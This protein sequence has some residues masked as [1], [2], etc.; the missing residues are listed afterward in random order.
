LDGRD[1][2]NLCGDLQRTFGTAAFAEQEAARELSFVDSH[3]VADPQVNLNE[4]AAALPRTAE[5]LDMRTMFSCLRHHHPMAHWMP[6]AGV[7][8]L[9]KA[10]GA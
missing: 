1:F 3:G 6:G 2:G 8:H 10:A 9:I 5:R 4:L 7:V